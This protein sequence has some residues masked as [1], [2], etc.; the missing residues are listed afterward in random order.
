MKAKPEAFAGLVT[1]IRG[2]TESSVLRL[3]RID[4]EP[5]LSQGS[6]TLCAT[7][8]VVHWIVVR[9]SKRMGWG[10]G[11]SAMLVNYDIVRRRRGDAYG[12]IGQA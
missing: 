6:R 2:V 12:R 8:L 3:E 5:L 11:Q 1:K 7:L 10:N 9:R 4:R